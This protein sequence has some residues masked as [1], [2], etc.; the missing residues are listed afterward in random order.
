MLF[1]RNG[2]EEPF[3]QWNVF[4]SEDS[5]L[6]NN[7]RFV[8]STSSIPNHTKNKQVDRGCLIEDL[9]KFRQ[10]YLQEVKKTSQYL[11]RWRH[12]TLLNEQFFV[13][14]LGWQFEQLSASLLLR[15]P[16][17]FQIKYLT[18]KQ[19]VSFGQSISLQHS[20][21]HCKSRSSI[22]SIRLAL[23]TADGYPR[24]CCTTKWDIQAGLDR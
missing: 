7:L 21:L 8:Y 2:F 4:S 3:F 20:N 15:A 24:C 17:L 23:N 18:A 22:C 14:S 19:L 16:G 9:S 11:Y 1:W 10:R 13:S 12:L 6:W 5:E